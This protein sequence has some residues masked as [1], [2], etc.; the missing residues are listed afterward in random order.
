MEKEVDLCWQKVVE[1][2]THL[3]DEEKCTLQIKLK[4][5][6]LLSWSVNKWMNYSDDLNSV[7][8]LADFSGQ[9]LYFIEGFIPLLSAFCH[10]MSLHL[11]GVNIQC[12]QLPS[13]KFTTI[14]NFG[15]IL[16]V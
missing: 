4:N 9:L 12:H 10:E 8:K 2:I 14:R 13:E 15:N 11:S 16:T 3:I 6:S 5:L 7:V 1:P